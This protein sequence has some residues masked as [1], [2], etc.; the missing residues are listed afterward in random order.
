MQFGQEKK[1][2]PPKR[3]QMKALFAM[4][5]ICLG[6]FECIGLYKNADGTYTH[7]FGDQTRVL[8]ADEIKTGKQF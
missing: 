4:I 8:V 5:L 6:G 3:R 2:R 1:K 7:K